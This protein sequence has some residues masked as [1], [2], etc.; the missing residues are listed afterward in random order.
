MEEGAETKNVTYEK[1][2]ESKEETPRN[3]DGQNMTDLEELVLCRS[4]NQIKV[5]VFKKEYLLIN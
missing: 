3:N 5:C 2:E 4:P 1:K